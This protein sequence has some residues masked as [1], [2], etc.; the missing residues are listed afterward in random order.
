MGILLCGVKTYGKSLRK[1]ILISIFVETKTGWS[2][3]ENMSAM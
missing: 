1:W 3:I 2:Y